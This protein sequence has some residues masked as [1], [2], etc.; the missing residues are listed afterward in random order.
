MQ[1]D[2]I[3]LHQ[4]ALVADLHCDTA[5]QIQRG[6]DFSKRHNT[7]HIDL[8]RLKE[9]GINL[10]VFA[11]FLNSNILPQSRFD[12]VNNMI[13]RL[14][15]EIAKNENNIAI[16]HNTTEAND[17]IDSGRIAAFLGIENGM[18]LDNK[19]ENI[20][21]FYQQGI[22]YITL[23]HFISHEWCISSMDKNPAF[24]G[25][26]DFGRE[27]IREMNR[28]GMIVDV[29]H[30]SVSAFNEVLKVTRQPVIASHSCVYALC[31][32]NR[33]L[34][35]EQLKTLAENG[36]MVGI[37]FCSDFL[38][39]QFMQASQAYRDA[40]PQEI[41]ILEK[42]L[43]PDLSEDD[44]QKKLK[45]LEPFLSQWDKAV[46]NMLPT[47]KTVVDH[48]D[49]V[50]DLVGVDYVGLGSD[51]DGISYP[52]QD[53]ADCSMVPNITRELVKRHYTESDI[54]KILGGNFMRVFK[55]VCG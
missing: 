54:E 5:L 3:H 55:L 26:T 35:D 48:I 46:K 33:N 30:I 7:Y 24:D 13:S 6:Y 49:Y 9:G 52:P 50:V 47:V 21:Y 40:H 15:T 27:V 14:K 44:Y 20:A 23:T 18:A 17:I 12:Y 37:N 53:L 8:P 41:K 2:Y 42:I 39:P 16:C 28:I 11:C 38:S 36:G 19:L 4:K 31:P 29:S 51:F 22:R 10:Q 32:H 45:E 34:T 43:I 25:L 1:L